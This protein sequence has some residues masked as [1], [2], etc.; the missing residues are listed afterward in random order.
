MPT[1]PVYISYVANQ[2][3]NTRKLLRSHLIPHVT[4]QTPVGICNKYTD[5]EAGY[6]CHNYIQKQQF[7]RKDLVCWSLTSL[8]HSNGHIATMPAQEINPFT[9]LTSIQ[10]QFIRTQ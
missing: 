3:A 5:F 10:S 9:A 6:I 7:T 1:T 4:N 2:D 8:C